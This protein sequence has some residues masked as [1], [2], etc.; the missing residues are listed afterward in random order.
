MA[1]RTAK[2][3]YY[4]LLLD[5]YYRLGTLRSMSRVATRPCRC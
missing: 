5:L 4:R 2:H 3:G 1:R